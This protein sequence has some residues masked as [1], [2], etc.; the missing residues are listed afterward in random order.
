MDWISKRLL[1]VLKLRQLDLVGIFFFALVPHRHQ[2]AAGREPGGDRGHC[3][4]AGL[5]A[6]PHGRDQ[7]PG[8]ETQVQGSS[9]H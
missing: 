3:D 8:G 7:T 5:P 4:A 9:C 2:E 1:N 6:P